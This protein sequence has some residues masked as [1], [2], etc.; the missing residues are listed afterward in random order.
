MTKTT[1]QEETKT[2]MG[3]KNENRTSAGDVNKTEQQPV[4]TRRLAMDNLRDSFWYLKHADELE[5]VTAESDNADLGIKRIG[6]FPPSEAQAN[7]AVIASIQLE[8]IVGNIRGIQVKE[9][10][11]TAGALYLQTGSK[12]IAREGQQAKWF[13]EVTLERVVTAQILSYV[14]SL[15]EEVK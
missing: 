9:S 14:D 3:A 11:N 8:T 6:V 2:K 4:T 12:N 1:V 13:N 15:L 5:K 10:K 7:N